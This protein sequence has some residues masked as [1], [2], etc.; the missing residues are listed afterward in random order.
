MGRLIITAQLVLF[1]AWVSAQS[2]PQMHKDAIREHHT[3]QIMGSS[4][5][6]TLLQPD[7]VL[8]RKIFERRANRVDTQTL[9]DLDPVPMAQVFKKH[10]LNLGQLLSVT[11]A[12]SGYDPVFH[13]QVNQQ[14]LVKINSLPNSLDAIAEYVT[15]VSDAHVSVW[16]ESRVLM[17]M[18]KGTQ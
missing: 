17:V 14:Q 7:V 18:P 2:M 15:R 4:Q 11:A 13:P 16:Q 12:A 3:K 8:Y 5:D 6:L 1:S 9:P 10:D